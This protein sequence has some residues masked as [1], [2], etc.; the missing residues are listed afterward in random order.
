[1]NIILQL[2]LATVLVAGIY[3]GKP[4]VNQAEVLESV[5]YGTEERGTLEDIETGAED[6]GRR[7]RGGRRGG[8][9]RRGRG[10]ENM[11]PDQKMEFICQ[12]LASA[13]TSPTLRGIMAKLNRM[14][15]DVKATIS[16]ALS[17]KKAEMI[18]CCQ[19]AGDDRLTCVEDARLARYDRVCSGTEPLCIWAILKGA[20]H[21]TS[22]I[23]DRCCALEG[24]ERSSCFIAARAQYKRNAR[25][26][27]RQRS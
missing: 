5:F 23:T 3:A 20:N 4:E 16:T 17:T 12:N 9:G 18:N 24:T 14:E 11:T 26:Q 15:A 13:A 22:S 8:N 25:L 7:G 27:R 1:M 21:D 10:R 19:M 6:T 2:L